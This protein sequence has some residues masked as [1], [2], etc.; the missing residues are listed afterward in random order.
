MAVHAS[1]GRRHRYRGFRSRVL[2]IS[3]AAVLALP[4]SIGLFPATASAATTVQWTNRGLSD[5]FDVIFGANADRARAVVDAALR[6][7]AR[8]LPALNR[9]S[10]PG[11]DTLAITVNA[12]P[13]TPNRC[14][15][16]ASGAFDA[17]GWPVGGAINVNGMAPEWFVDP[18]PHDHSE[19]LGT[20]QN[21]FAGDAHSGSPARGLCDLYTLVALEATHILGITSNASARW[22]NSGHNTQVTTSGTTCSGPG[23]FYEFSGPRIRH[24][25]TSHDSGGGDTGVPVHTAEP[26]GQF[27]AAD[28]LVLSGADDVG[29]AFF[30]RSRRYLPNNALGLILADVYG[31]SLVEPETFG[32]LYATLNGSELLVRGGMANSD[33]GTAATSG[34]VITITRSGGNIT[35]SVDVGNDVVGTGPTDEFIST[36]S[37]G[38]V[39]SIRILSADGGD[40]ISVGPGLAVPVNIDADSGNDVVHVATGVGGPV[41][42]AGGD[43]DDTIS[44]AE[45][46]DGGEGNDTLTGTDGV[47]VLTG[48]AGNDRLIGLAGD[49]HLTGGSGDDQ[50]YGGTGSNTASDGTGADLV[51]LSGNAV[52]VT[53]QTEGGNDT[54]LGTAFDD[55]L[56][57]TSGNDQLEGGAGLDF[58]VGAAGDDVLYGG[59]GTDYLTGGPGADNSH[60][61]DGSDVIRWLEGDS[62]DV[63]EGGAGE[64]D[65]VA[66]Q[67]ADGDDVIQMVSSAVSRVTVRWSGASPFALNMASVEDVS[68]NTGGGT[69][70]VDV[71][72]LTDTELRKLMVVAGAGPSEQ[73]TI[74]GGDSA[75]RLEVSS[76]SAG[77]ARIHGLPYTPLILELTAADRLVLDGRG[78]ADTVVANADLSSGSYRVTPTGAQSADIEAFEGI[79]L[80]AVGAEMLLVKGDDSG[81]SLSLSSPAGAQEVLV[82]AG[83]APDAGQVTIQNYLPVSFSNLGSAGQVSVEDALKADTLTYSGTPTNDHFSILSGGTGLQLNDRIPV[84]AQGADSVV[85]QGHAGDDRFD[86]PADLSFAATGVDGGASSND[87]LTLATADGPV[88]VDLQTSSINGYGAGPIHVVDVEQVSSQ[89]Q[90]EASTLTVLGSA[91][92]DDLRYLPTG[93]DA[94]SLSGAPFELHFV[95][96]AGGLTVDPR[97]GSDRLTVL[98]GIAD[99][100]FDVLAGEVTTVQVGA[101]APLAV[102]HASTEVV[103][104]FGADGTDVFD[105]TTFSTVS[106]VLAVYGDSPAA[107][108]FSDTLVLRDGSGKAQFRDV[109]GHEFETGS[110]FAAYKS[111][112]STRVD[113]VEMESVQFVRK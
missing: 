5:G 14:G 2:G 56:T 36:F 81:K 67:A 9:R 91:G 40:T 68:L 87:G 45:T 35:A 16:S 79:A 61:G 100:R 38:R 1:L 85:L 7:W 96:V 41:T 39:T 49:D 106:P 77:V 29:N 32:T 59:A 17:D 26:C 44:G 13:G 57:G 27:T 112:H 55:Q 111:G 3:A 31:Y 108:R 71:G 50:I 15:G 28:G 72:D 52:G 101:L 42:V 21:A 34:D 25:I 84:D 8:A 23:N 88:A 105:I 103:H 20:I 92:A 63:I 37:S 76:P 70:S 53:Y 18:T 109:K 60:G 94:G 51:D 46:A 75:D 99:D 54:V 78:G 107:K 69:D 74:A 113:Y 12:N 65:R 6:D 30:E 64:S 90:G 83:A 43:G 4:L 95:G 19:F 11:S 10:T 102:P 86:L 89:Q 93:E 80:G 104:M 33:T 82:A 58:L 48:G 73:V 24:L 110:A 22:S 98:G 47:D 62:G 97:A 66:I